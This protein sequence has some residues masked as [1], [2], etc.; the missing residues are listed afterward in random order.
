MPYL[1]LE[2]DGV[3]RKIVSLAGMFALLLC[4]MP[5]AALKEGD[6]R[7]QTSREDAFRSMYPSAERFQA[8]VCR[9]SPE[10]KKRVEQK[11]GRK[12]AADTVT[13][14]TAIRGSTRLGTAFVIDEIG[15]HYPITF[16]IGLDAEGRVRDCIVLVY[17]ESRG[18]EIKDSRFRRQFVG[19]SPADPLRIRRDVI[20]ITGATY[21]C[22]AATDAIRKAMAY[23]AECRGH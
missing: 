12:V 13:H 1:G 20:N 3:G 19:K 17:R 16:A 15:Q 14:W 6:A 5:A 10:A 8:E 2:T 11:S 4:A 18:S 9:L 21:S 22:R 7:V 23:Q